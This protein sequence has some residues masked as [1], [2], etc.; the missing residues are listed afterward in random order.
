MKV[1]DVATSLKVMLQD[2][3]AYSDWA[4]RFMYHKGSALHWNTLVQK[5]PSNRLILS[6]HTDFSHYR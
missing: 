1:W 3:K 2:F 5:V 6:R 4:L